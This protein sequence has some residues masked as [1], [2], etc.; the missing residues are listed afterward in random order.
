MP[1][2]SSRVGDHAA[3][4]DVLAA[5]KESARPHADDGFARAVAAWPRWD[6]FAFVDACAK[7]EERFRRDVQ[8][9]EIEVLLE[10]CVVQAH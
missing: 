1:T 3:F 8:V 5:A 9:R 10:W 2:Q 4:G 7:G 6:P